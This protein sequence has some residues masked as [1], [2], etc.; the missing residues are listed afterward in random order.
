VRPPPRQRLGRLL[1]DRRL[2]DLLGEGRDDEVVEAIR[3]G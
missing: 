2:A 1:G 3:R